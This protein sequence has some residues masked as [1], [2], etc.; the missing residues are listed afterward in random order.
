MIYLN[1]TPFK[2]TRFPDGTCGKFDF[3]PF[4]IHNWDNWKIDWRYESDEELVELM[5]LVNHIRQNFGNKDIFLYLYYIPN[6]RMDR[7]K[8]KQK[9]IFTLKYFCDFINSLKF[10][11]VFVLDPH[12]DVSVALLNNVVVKEDLLNILINKTLSNVFY[13][14]QEKPIIYFPDAGAVKRYSFLGCFKNYEY[15][16]GVKTRDWSTGK[17][18]GIEICNKNGYK[19]E[20]TISVD[21]ETKGVGGDMPIENTVITSPI[22]NR[23]ILMVD[24]IVS[25]G[26][27][28]SYSADKLK[29][30]G[31]GNIYAY[32]THAENSVIDEEKSSLLKNFKNK[33]VKMLFTS[34]SIFNKE[35]EFVKTI[36]I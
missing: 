25:Y 32:A 23:V 11:E 29:E 9:E 15:I 27:T 35:S 8:N 4:N 1:E 18:N 6:A 3:N 17:I 30:Y 14:E 21:C 16:Y 2:M 19:I 5:Y 12:S 31:V 10:D 22:S 13:I 33:T 20:N 26:G 36:K 24:D 28:L 7:T 34:N